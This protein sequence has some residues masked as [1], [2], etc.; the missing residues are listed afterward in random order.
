MSELK[1]LKVSTETHRA[2]TDLGRKG[3]TY[4][5]ILR[6][7]MREKDIAEKYIYGPDD[8]ESYQK[9]LLGEEG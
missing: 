4:D 1:S 2:L 6:R 3:E 7:L 5:A 9:E 8:W